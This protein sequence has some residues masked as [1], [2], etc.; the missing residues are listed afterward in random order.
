MIS[1][2]FPRVKTRFHLQYIKF[3]SILI[4][5][6][7]YIPLQISCFVCFLRRYI[8]TAYNKKYKR[9]VLKYANKFLFVFAGRI[10]FLLTTW[11][12]FKSLMKYPVARYFLFILQQK[13]MLESSSKQVQFVNFKSKSIDKTNWMEFGI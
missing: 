11:V 1:T 9:G 10:L 5:F 13:F 7:L 2:L 3:Y 12:F 8:K 6:T 4:L